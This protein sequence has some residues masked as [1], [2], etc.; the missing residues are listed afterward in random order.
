MALNGALGRKGGS[1]N[2]TD[3]RATI[4]ADRGD[5]GIKIQSS[6]L[7]VTAYGLKGL[8]AAQFAELAKEAEGRCP[9]SNAYRGTMTITV[10]AHV[11]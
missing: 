5:A 1:A 6:A 10:E 11:K 2:H 4:T 9:V 7:V 3:V 8:D